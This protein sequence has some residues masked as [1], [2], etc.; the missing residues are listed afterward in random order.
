[1]GGFLKERPVRGARLAQVLPVL[2]R[3]ASGRADRGEVKGEL[4]QAA[5]GGESRAR[6]E[7]WTAR[8]V[9]R[10]LE[11]GLIADALTTLAGHRS[12]GDRLVLLSASTDLY[13]PAIG[14]A[15]GFDEVLC[16]G[17]QWDG[18]RLVGRLSTPNRRGAE[19]TRCLV[20]LRQRYP[21]VPIVAYANAASDLE[22]LRLADRAVLVNGTPRARR[23]A[24]RAG[25]A[26]VTWR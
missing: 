11:H 16:T 22:H 24:R 9:A 14:R 18:D 20:G 4:I 26:C 15:L 1:V 19:K 3:F 13:V 2:A 10:V 25:V 12:A 23:A 21:G 6:L 5:L 8:F 17:V 7:A